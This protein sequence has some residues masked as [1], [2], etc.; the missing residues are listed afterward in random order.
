MRAFFFHM[1][2]IQRNLVFSASVPKSIQSCFMALFIFPHTYTYTYTGTA[3][4]FRHSGKSYIIGRIY[5]THLF[6]CESVCMQYYFA[7]CVSFCPIPFFLQRIVC[8][9][10]KNRNISNC[11]LV[12]KSVQCIVHI[13]FNSIVRE[14]LYGMN[15]LK[16]SHIIFYTSHICVY[17][18]TD[19][20]YVKKLLFPF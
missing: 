1:L 6:V 11:K 17:I 20:K 2:Y 9:Q 12:P 14:N 7:A 15:L 13:S 18:F 4:A 10:S 19:C 3:K 16:F 5:I 8:V